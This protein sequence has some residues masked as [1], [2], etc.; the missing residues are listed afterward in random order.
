M[1]QLGLLF[2]LVGA[3]VTNLGMLW[4]H[5]GV[6]DVPDVNFAHPLKSAKILFS[7]KWYAIGWVVTL[8]AFVFHALALS[9]APISLVQAVLS[10]G[11]VFL[12][13]FATRFFGFSLGKKEWAGI[14]FVAVGLT[15]LGLTAHVASNVHSHYSLLAMIIFEAVGRRRSSASLLAS[16]GARP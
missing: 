14:G 12:A 5:K 10:G 3:V 7:S 15:F 6:V 11:L 13:V 16:R 8:L 2:A 4:K 1:L 9:M